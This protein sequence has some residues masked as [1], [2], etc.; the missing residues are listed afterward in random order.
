MKDKF[1]GISKCLMPNQNNN[2]K[3]QNKILKL[4]LYDLCEANKP[5]FKFT[6]LVVFYAIIDS[7]TAIRHFN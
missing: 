2:K 7:R 3:R 6:I 1:N 4:N 5:G